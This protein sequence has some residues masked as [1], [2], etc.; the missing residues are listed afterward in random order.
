MFCFPLDA[1][2]E[3][4][5]QP[6]SVFPRV[7]ISRGYLSKGGALALGLDGDGVS[8]SLEDLVDVF[9]TELGAF[10]LFVHQSS[11]CSLSQ[12]VLNFLFGQLLDLSHSHDTLGS[13]DGHIYH[14]IILPMD[15]C[16]VSYPAVG[17]LSAA[18]ALQ[19]G[20]V[21]AQLQT[22][23]IEHFPLVAVPGDEAVDLDSLGL[24]NPM[25]ASLGLQLAIEHIL[26]WGLSPPSH[27]DLLMKHHVASVAD[28][29]GFNIC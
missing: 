4:L 18:H 27:N 17:V 3:C 14:D 25:A 15:Q 2:F 26:K 8:A 16:V 9:L 21:K 6:L 5:Y 19:N 28:L 20:L 7:I 10:V 13:P 12:K 1:H 22:G 23:L 24:A 29:I 11:I